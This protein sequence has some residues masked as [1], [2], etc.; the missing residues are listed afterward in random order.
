MMH[1]RF[2]NQGLLEALGTSSDENISIVEIRVSRAKAPLT[3]QHMS[4]RLLRPED[5]ARALGDVVLTSPD[6]REDPK[7]RS[8]ESGPE[9]SYGVDYRALRWIQFL[10]PLRGLGM[11]P[12]V[13]RP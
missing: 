7:T 6:F 3:A 12:T 11:I 5:A 8:P 13:V 10:H 4:S 1:G 9:Y 2:L